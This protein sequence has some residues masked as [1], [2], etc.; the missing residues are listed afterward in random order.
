M[1]TKIIANDHIV[2]TRSDGSSQFSFSLRVFSPNLL[3]KIRLGIAIMI[4]FFL[5]DN[6]IAQI[7]WLFTFYFQS[8]DCLSHLEFAKCVYCILVHYHNKNIAFRISYSFITNTTA[9]GIRSGCNKNKEDNNTPNGVLSGS[10]AEWEDENP[11][12]RSVF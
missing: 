7:P 12:R 8:F 10:I 4:R 3:C 9:N 1:Q 11:L 6:F 2:L 5:K